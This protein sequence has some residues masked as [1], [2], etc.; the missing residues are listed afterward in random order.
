MAGLIVD[1]TAKMNNFRAILP[2]ATAKDVAESFMFAT[3]KGKATEHGLLSKEV[4]V[5]V[6]KW[7]I[8]EGQWYLIQDV[9]PCNP[10][11]ILVD[12]NGDYKFQVHYAT[13]ESGH[14]DDK[15]LDVILQQMKSSEY[16]ICPGFKDKYVEIKDILTDNYKPI[17]V[18]EWPGKIR[19][20]SI[21]CKLWYD[22]TGPD[23]RTGTR[24]MCWPCNSL[25]GSIR[26]SKKRAQ[27]R[28][29]EAEP[30]KCMPLKFMKPEIRRKVLRK[31]RKETY[32]LIKKLKKYE[33]TE[34]GSQDKEPAGT[35][36]T[37][38]TSVPSKNKSVTTKD[39][40]VTTKDT[41]VTTKDTSVPSKNKS[42]TTKDTTVTTTDTSVTTKDTSL[43]TK[44]T[45]ATKKN[46]DDH[47][48]P[49]EHNSDSASNE[50]V[51]I[52]QKKKV[53]AK[54]KKTKVATAVEKNN[55]DNATASVER[56]SDLAESIQKRNVA[57]KKIP[58][59]VGVAVQNNKVA[60]PIE[61][62]RNEIIACARKKKKTNARK[63]K[64]K[65]VASADKP[66]DTVTVAISGETIKDR[67][68]NATLVGKNKDKVV[69]DKTNQIVDSMEKNKDIMM[70]YSE[71]R[72]DNG[73]ILAEKIT[74][75]PME[76]AD[77]NSGNVSAD[78][79]E[80][81]E[82]I[83]KATGERNEDEMIT[84][85]E[86]NQKN[87]VTALMNNKDTV[88]TSVEEN[89]LKTENADTNVDQISTAEN[90]DKNIDQIG[91]IENA[92][93]RVDQ[94]AAIC[95]NNSVVA[96]SEKN[97][98]SLPPAN[99]LIDTAIVT[100]VEGIGTT[101]MVKI[102]DSGVVVAEKNQ[103]VNAAAACKNINKLSETFEKTKD[104]APASAKKIRDRFAVFAKK[105]KEKGSVSVKNVAI[106][107]E[108]F[109]YFTF[110]YA[111]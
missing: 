59:W 66:Q 49:V 42:V 25:L 64:K 86:K 23:L 104:T 107:L 67:S 101:S 34:S 29:G 75:R 85:F 13:L 38:D 91:A 53:T 20:D 63:S 39:T 103:D 21:D 54:K 16:T 70:A 108:N 96:P 3:V 26:Q 45:V 92:D 12:Q 58:E 41:S 9:G 78:V 65:S 6:K 57:G 8:I 15:N 61:K 82:E 47:A 80:N 56:N 44:D 36:T 77:V 68:H 110:F 10:V 90:A 87:S 94:S 22:R 40:P 52:A 102:E 100:P 109:V 30:P 37:K 89:D 1:I 31:K 74:D 19:Y 43:T 93:K 14:Y 5:G 7:L 2:R 111:L 81:K 24:Y 27:R 99:K 33:N 83:A 105:V 106:S 72:K 79:G 55:D 48:V 69:A 28:I 35:L 51:N 97:R 76:L 60:T 11:R 62:N 84:S 73:T 71:K 88:N 98:D 4:R 32:D 50:A 17:K 18:R 46:K 95:E